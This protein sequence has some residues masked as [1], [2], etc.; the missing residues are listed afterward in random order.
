MARIIERL[1]I[2]KS[3]R[4]SVS[5]K[6]WEVSTGLG[7]DIC[8]WHPEEPSLPCSQGAGPN[9]SESNS[10]GGEFVIHECEFGVR[11]FPADRGW[12]MHEKTRQKS[13]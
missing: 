8:E 3:E 11:L 5:S 2:Y 12:M 4:N 9:T 7:S 13:C 1:R 6:F 10:R